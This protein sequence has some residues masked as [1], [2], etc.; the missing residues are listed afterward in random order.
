MAATASFPRSGITAADAADASQLGFVL[1]AGAQSLRL[2]V[3]C[4]TG[5]ATIALSVYFLDA[6]Q[7]P[8]CVQRL[9]YTSPAVADWG[10]SF[11]GT[12]QYDPC[13]PLGGAKAVL[14]HVDE[15]SAGTWSIDAATS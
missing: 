10:K 2:G 6:A 9:E 4:D 8:I 5:A 1:V 15:V 13:W 3:T 11:V 12:P 14:V 7:Q